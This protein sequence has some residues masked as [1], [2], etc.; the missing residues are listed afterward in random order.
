MNP[1][2]LSFSIKNNGSFEILNSVGISVPYSTCSN[3]LFA[4]I[5]FYKIF[6]FH[7]FMK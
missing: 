2:A 7:I 1:N 3:A 5:D 4:K 6:M